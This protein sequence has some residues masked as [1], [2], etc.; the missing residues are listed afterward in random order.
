MP[1]WR[2]SLI[3][4]TVPGA[5]RRDRSS[6]SRPD[7]TTRSSAWTSV[8]RSASRSAP[9]RFPA[10]SGRSPRSA[11]SRRTSR[12][13]F[14]NRAGS[15]HP[16]PAIRGRGSARRSFPAVELAAAGVADADRDRIGAQLGTFLRALHA[17]RL[18]ARVG[19]S[20]PVDPNR[21]ADMGFRVRL[22][23]ER[24]AD[25][26][27]AGLWHG[28]AGGGRAAGGCR[29]PATAIAHGRPARRSPRSPRPR[30]GGRTHDRGERRDRLG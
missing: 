8:G 3:G 2:D 5:A 18:A 9:S 19:T 21:R 16:T 27:A 6:R 24:L 11:G 4:D 20:L 29:G 28:D 7:G 13:R 23:R 15:G 17:P 10:S 12:S 1:R 26:V 30:G 14:P 25:L 22:T